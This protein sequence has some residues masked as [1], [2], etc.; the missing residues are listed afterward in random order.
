MTKLMEH[1]LRL[2]ECKKRWSITYRRCKVTYD[3]D[4]WGLTLAIYITLLG[5][6]TTPCTTALRLTWVWIEV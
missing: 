2:I 5:E 4:N 3:T 6:V 1:S